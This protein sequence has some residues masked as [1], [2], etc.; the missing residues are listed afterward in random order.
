MRLAPAGLLAACSG[1]TPTVGA[2]APALVCAGVR[3]T[4]TG[5]EFRPLA[6]PEPTLSLPQ[7]F[8]LPAQGEPIALEGTPWDSQSQMSFAVPPRTRP[9][10]YGVPVRNPHGTEGSL[11]PARAPIA[12]PV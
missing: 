1:A 9:G 3:V 2:V 4:V 10:A 11:P 7:G 6:G 12:P 8:L 5:S